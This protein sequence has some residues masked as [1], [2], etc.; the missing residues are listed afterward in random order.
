[1][2]T[3]LTSSPPGAQTGYRLCPTKTF[4]QR[5]HCNVY[6]IV[7][8]VLI[9][10]YWFCLDIGFNT[11]IPTDLILSYSAVLIDLQSLSYLGLC[12]Q[13]KNNIGFLIKSL[14]FRYPTEVCMTQDPI[15]RQ[16]CIVWDPKKCYFSRPILKSRPSST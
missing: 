9:S 11:D 6:L 2:F 13:H 5:N 1:M 4:S 7:L 14:E 3:I 10:G 16:I 15:Y 12:D 8:I